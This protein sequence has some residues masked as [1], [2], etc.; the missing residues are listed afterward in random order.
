MAKI[1]RK[2]KKIKSLPAKKPLKKATSASSTSSSCSVMSADLDSDPITTTD[3]AAAAAAAGPGRG[4]RR[5][6]AGRKSVLDDD[7]KNKSRIYIGAS[8]V[9]KWEKLKRAYGDQGHISFTSLLLEIAEKRLNSDGHTIHSDMDTSRQQ[10]NTDDEFICLQ[11]STDL[12]Y[13]FY[14]LQ[15]HSS[16]RTSAFLISL[17]IL[18]CENQQLDIKRL[19]SF[20][21]RSLRK[22]TKSR[23]EDVVVSDNQYSTSSTAADVGIVEDSSVNRQSVR[24]VS[25]MNM[26]DLN[27]DMALDLLVRTALRHLGPAS[28]ADC[29]EHDRSNTQSESDHHQCDHIDVNHSVKG[30]PTVA[31]FSIDDESSSDLYSSNPEQ[32]NNKIKNR[33]HVY[34]K[35]TNKSNKVFN[36]MDVPGQT[37]GQTNASGHCTDQTD[38]SGQ[39]VGLIYVA[40]QPISQSDV[41]GQSF[42]QTDAFHQLIGQTDGQI[43]VSGKCS[44]QKDASGQC[45]GHIYVSGQSVGQTDVSGQSVCQTDVSGHAVG[46]TDVSG[47]CTGQNDASGQ[48]TGH[49]D[50]SGQTVGQTDVSGQCTGQNDA[51]GQY[52]G[53]TDG[54]SQT[55]GQT[56]VSGQCT[57]QTDVSGQSVSQTDTSGQSAGLSDLSGQR[58]GQSD[59]PVQSVSQTDT[60][61]QSAGLSDLSGQRTGQ[62]DVPVQSVSQTDTVSLSSQSTSQTDTADQSIINE[63]NNDHEDCLYVIRDAVSKRDKPIKERSINSKLYS[64]DLCELS[65]FKT[66]HGLY[67]HKRSVHSCKLYMCDHVESCGKAFNSAAMRKKHVDRVH[68]RVKP[69]SCSYETCRALFFSKDELNQH[70][71]VHHTREKLHPCSWDDCGLTFRTKYQL[72]VH[73]RCH[74]DE[75]PVKCPHDNCPYRARQQS[76]LRWH[77]KKR[78]GGDQQSGPAGSGGKATG[79]QSKKIVKKPSERLNLCEPIMI[80]L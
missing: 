80:D 13:W 26:E 17:L 20:G 52:T 66:K 71:R 35:G 55:V 6:G 37:V 25:D 9:K 77:L 59:V 14:K 61:S 68:L 16:L 30:S 1:S 10:Q 36:Q 29:A 64:C 22:T 43:D 21:P 28:E 11:V 56:D 2:K 50:A 53:H 46:Q 51:F 32:F 58:T 7:E 41:S 24:E 15:N 8:N 49:T 39:S 4:G 47:Q 5:T 27:D 75:K 12:K 76:S 65:A 63:K 45:T 67:K 79:N 40:G 48:C 73:R 57:G 23:S 18:Y 74:T 70:V 72:T 38:V 3:A 60:S 62:S 69:F 34:H 33:V 42:S 19:K 31:S 78:H 54:Y 44:G